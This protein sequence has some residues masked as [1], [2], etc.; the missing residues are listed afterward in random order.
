[1]VDC[2]R[3]AEN[4]QGRKLRLLL[5]GPTL[6]EELCSATDKIQGSLCKLHLVLLNLQSESLVYIRHVT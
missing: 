4:W 3:V 5:R 6:A 1:M 2:G